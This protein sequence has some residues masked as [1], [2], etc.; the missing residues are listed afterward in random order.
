[1]SGWEE[2]TEVFHPGD[3]VTWR[4][5]PPHGCHGAGPF[6]VL[7]V[8]T[9]PANACCCGGRMND[10]I[11]RCFPY[12]Q[13]YKHCRPLRE[14]VKHSQQV[15]LADEKGRAIGSPRMSGYWIKRIEQ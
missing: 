14:S 2:N 11:H 10:K 12:H 3:L 7:A 5:G 15:Q 4:N 8:R 13:P 6:L 1:M 9:V